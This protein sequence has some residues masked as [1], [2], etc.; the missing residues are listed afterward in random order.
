MDLTVCVAVQDN[1]PLCGENQ[2]SWCA[3][4]AMIVHRFN[5]LDSTAVEVY[6]TDGIDYFLVSGQPLREVLLDPSSYSLIVVCHLFSPHLLVD[7]NHG[8]LE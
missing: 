4:A 7:W 5:V 6:L 8:H 2:E 3:Y 1:Q